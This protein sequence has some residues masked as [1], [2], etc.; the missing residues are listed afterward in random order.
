MKKKE[1][2]MKEQKRLKYM[3]DKYKM[4]MIDYKNN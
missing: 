2:L 1:N 4:K 3:V